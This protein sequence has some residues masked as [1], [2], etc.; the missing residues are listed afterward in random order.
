MIAVSLKQNSNMIDLFQKK[1]RQWSASIGKISLH[2]DR[3]DPALRI[4]DV[5]TNFGT[6][7][8]WRDT[9]WLTLT[10][11]KQP[12]QTS[13]DL[14]KADTEV[15][16]SVLWW[17]PRGPVHSRKMTAS[18]QTQESTEWI[19]EC[20]IGPEGAEWGCSGCPDDDVCSALIVQRASWSI[21]WVCFLFM[22]RD[23]MSIWCRFNRSM[24]CSSTDKTGWQKKASLS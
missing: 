18:W 8:V 20:Y 5:D 13:L 19:L 6:T 1:T 12:W 2:A 17:K 4:R 7:A 11:Q 23:D 9:H 3:A 16:Q 22:L 24:N 15:L 21:C 10:C 14:P